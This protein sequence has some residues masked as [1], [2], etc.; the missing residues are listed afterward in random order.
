MAEGL[1]QRIDS[2]YREVE[3]LNQL[4]QTIVASSSDTKAQS[5]SVLNINLGL[6]NGSIAYV[7]HYQQ[8]QKH[9][10]EVLTK[11]IRAE[12]VDVIFI[13]ELWFKEDFTA[14][15]KMAKREGFEVA[16]PD[17]Q[18]S[19][20]ASKYGMQ[21]YVRTAAL[22]PGSKLLATKLT[23]YSRTTRLEYIGGYKKALLTVSGTLANGQS[24]LF[25]NTHLSATV[26]ANG[27]RQIQIKEAAAELEKQAPSKALTLFGADF[28]VSP[29]FE[30]SLSTEVK[31]WEENRAPYVEFHEAT[32]LM[33]AFKALHPK[34]PGYTWDKRA[35]TNISDGPAAIKDEPLQRTDFIWVGE[36]THTS[37]AT[38]RVVV[39]SCDLV[40]TEKVVPVEKQKVH[41]TDHFA[42]FARFKILD[43]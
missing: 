26:G 37:P 38:P 4:A 19:A 6:L 14:A 31:Q 12:N 3:R 25:A 17:R 36:I 22:A 33:D 35:N 28:N 11:F 18:Y 8:R 27:I 21:I 41:L 5:L 23:D 9:F 43:N 34:D 32:H 15:N 10:I 13:Q 20:Q 16:I 7:P 30:D 29:E 42:V 2:T 39:E 24:A 40:F 1:S